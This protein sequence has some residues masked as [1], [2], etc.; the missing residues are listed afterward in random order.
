[1]E[2]IYSTSTELSPDF[3]SF[4]EAGVALAQAEADFP[5]LSSM[6]DT[7]TR[8]PFD[9][10]PSVTYSGD[11]AFP[12][13]CPFNNQ[14]P[15]VQAT[16]DI[17]FLSPV[18]WD[19]QPEPDTFLNFPLAQSFLPEDVLFSPDVFLPAQNVS[20]NRTFRGRKSKIACEV[21]P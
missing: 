17:G 19:S 21:Y 4:Y 7:S 11:P 15:L 10:C 18:L 20:Y 8:P 3:S 14:P 9:S 6:H 5:G 16:G 12:V 2:F 13:P 1:M